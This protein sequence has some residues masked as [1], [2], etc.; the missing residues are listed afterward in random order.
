MACP[1]KSTLPHP[2]RVPVGILAIIIALTSAWLGALLTLVLLPGMWFMA[3]GVLIAQLIAPE[4]LMS[5]WTIGAIV[6]LAAVGEIAEFASSAAGAK[7]F[8]ASK[9]GMTGAVVGSLV[10]ALLGTVLIPIPIAGTL[11]GAVLGAGLAAAGAER[12]VA[13][14]NWRESSTSATGAALGRVAA[15]AI[16]GGLA[17]VQA[18]VVTVA[19]FL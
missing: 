12:G 5:W 17:V 1:P 9:A 11:V 6:G 15:V 8:G 7:Q 16:K 4:P 3:L 10:G 2:E 13:G 18:L 14:R 19:A